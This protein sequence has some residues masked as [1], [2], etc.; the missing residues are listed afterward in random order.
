MNLTGAQGKQLQ[1]AFCAPT[2]NPWE[3]LGYGQPGRTQP[4]N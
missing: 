2:E 1:L 3:L 4:G